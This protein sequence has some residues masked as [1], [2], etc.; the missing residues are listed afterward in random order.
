MRK[1]K[2]NLRHIFFVLSCL[3]AISGWALTDGSTFE[4]NVLGYTGWVPV[5]YKVIS[6]A[7]HTCQ[8]GDGT[9]LA[10][11]LTKSNNLPLTSTV[12]YNGTTEYTV[13]AIAANAFKDCTKLTS[14]DIPETVT[15]IGE[16]AFYGCTGIQTIDFYANS[17]N[18]TL[19]TIGDYAFS[20]CTS[21][22]YFSSPSGKSI[23]SSVTS[24]GQDAFRNC[25]FSFFTIPEGV[26]TINA[27]TFAYCENLQK[28]TI[29]STVTSIGN[30]AFR[31]CTKLK[32]I[33]SGIQVPF[34]PGNYAFDEIYSNCIVGVPAGTRDAYIAAGWTT[35]SGG[36]FGEISEPVTITVRNCT[37]HF[38][39]AIPNFDYDVT[40][41][42]LVASLCGYPSFSTNAKADS[43]LGTYNIIG[44]RGTVNEAIDLTFVN[45][46]LTVDEAPITIKAK[47]QSVTYGNSISTETS[48]VTTTGLP[49]GYT[50][51]EI[52]LTPSISNAGTG[53]ITPSEAKITKNG[54]DEDVTSK[55]VFTYQTGTLTI[56]T[57][58]IGDVTVSN[59]AQQTYI[60]S[61]I[62]PEVTVTDGNTP[63]VYD[64]DYTVTY[65]NNTNAGN[66]TVKITGKGNY[67]SYKNVTFTIN[68]KPVTITAKAQTLNYGSSISQATSQVTCNDLVSGHSI[69]SVTLTQSTTDLTT[70]GTITPSAATIK[71][72]SN[73][74][75][76][77]NYA[78]TYA[79]GNLTINGKPASDLTIESIGSTTYTGTAQTPSV[80]VKDGNTT[81]TNGTHY[82][83]AYTNNT[84]AGTATVTITGL[85]TY[86]GSKS[87]T[88]TINKA[89]LTITAQSYTINEKE[90]L[91]T[92]EATY[93]GF[94]NNETSAVLT[95]Q[96]TFS[97]SATSSD[98]PGAYTIT[99]SG[100]EAA[101]YTISYVNGT[102]T[103]ATVES[104]SIAMNAG[105]GKPRSM[106]GYSSQYGLDFTSVSDVKAYIVLGYKN[107]LETILLGRVKIVPP[108][109]G[110]VL[111]TDN[112]G[113][114][115][116]VPTTTE[117]Y[118]Y[119]NLLRPM[120]ETTT[121]P[122]TET[123]NGKEYMNFVVGTLTGGEMGFVRLNSSYT[124][125]NKSYLPV[126]A[127]YYEN[128]AGVRA[129]G[130]FDIEIVDSETTD[131][132]SLLYNPS[133]AQDKFYDLQ[134]RQVIP[135]KK[136]I[137]I[138]NG[139][140]VFIK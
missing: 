10:I 133:N 53:T 17:A 15:S 33:K 134:G 124:T 1:N 16:R 114:V 86:A 30:A 24:I 116:D 18:P 5:K 35:G 108:H 32:S 80:T 85:T 66:A 103:I 42:P 113:V 111:M 81:L 11:D 70:N 25:Y 31:N 107:G 106:K 14:V 34:T 68:Q 95:K 26:T 87:A 58:Y 122:A 20:G 96:P 123:V 93:T 84:N 78:I 28:I 89:P 119:A 50:L 9:N 126:L 102:L 37:K 52:T 43:D 112:P 27:T 135:G 6:E 137:Y 118:V 104:V 29:P 76:T 79:S 82:T 74:D 115:V 12:L 59:I 56:N 51:S 36:K 90:T 64:T 73:V 91:P 57:K 128:N 69:K 47:N 101:N 49:S 100:A 48:K 67:H 129:K 71:N 62:T 130:G 44:Y 88:F 2:L 117:D 55:F 13:I 77:S 63:L 83:V 131:I 105:E 38:G 21:L 45:G 98:T 19:E 94:V 23:P 40:G 136:G 132:N 41:G 65:S 138:Q 39:A 3:C 60:G 8:V 109:T 92:Y 97:C 75:V 72:S 125:S 110:I 4:A 46:T 54:T 127:N 139:K 22:A 7:D 140:K 121:I 61:A 120:V 99:P